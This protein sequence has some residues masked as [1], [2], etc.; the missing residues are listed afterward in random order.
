[1]IKGVIGDWAYVYKKFI[2]ESLYK[3]LQYKVIENDDGCDVEVVHNLYEELDNGIVA[4][5]RYCDFVEELLLEN[6]LQDNRTI[7]DDINIELKVDP[8]DSYQLDAVNS[9]LVNDHGILFAKTAFGKTYVAINTIS[10]LKKKTLI[11]MHKKD[12][13]TQ[14]K[15]DIIKYTNLTDNDVQIFTGSKFEPNKP[16]TITTVQ[17]ICSKIRRDNLELRDILYKENFGITIYDECHR[18]MGPLDT[19]K[20][21][22][23]VF[24]KR[25]YGLSATPFRGD[26][27]DIVIKNILGKVIYIDQRK[28]LPVYVSFAPF[29]VPVPD[30]T[31]YYFSK[32]DKLY[33]LR[34]N[35]W[36]TKQPD[37]LKHCSEIILDLIKVNRKVLIVAALKDVL[38]SVYDESCKLLFE[39]GIETNRMKVIHGTSEESFE[40]VKNMSKE[41]INNFNCIFSTNKFF[42]DG[43]SINWLDTI[44]YLTPPSSSSLSAIPQ[45]VGRIVR[46]YENKEYVIVIDLFNDSFDIEKYR[47]KK[48]NIAYKNLGYEILPLTNVNCNQITEYTIKT[49]KQLKEEFIL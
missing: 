11:L 47:Y 10:K 3:S 44:L 15:D 25:V 8:R 12:L 32:S 18:T 16:I 36:L 43:L 40:S 5:P 34:Y 9:M 33:T 27:L 46:E 35:K 26:D 49:I 1:M 41:E 42:S 4:L 13:M 29:S 19:T 2:P 28:M 31:K 37:Y 20:T 14:W 45:L 17:N 38:N 24:S 6:S 48:R 23:W 21:S 7:G 22:R 39:N 30:K